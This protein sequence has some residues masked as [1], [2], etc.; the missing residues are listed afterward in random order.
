MFNLRLDNPT[1]L[2]QTIAVLNDFI[3]EATFSFQKDGIKLVAM[4]PA[5]I[6]MVSLDLLPSAFSEYN[7]E[8]AKELTLNLNYLQQALNR[9]RSNDAIT[10]AP[11]K[12][13]LKVTILGKS[14]KRFFIP[15]L[16]KEGKERA[17]PDLSFKAKIELDTNEFK[18]Y[19]DD[20]SVVGDAMTFEA[21]ED[22]INLSAGEIGSQ[23]QIEVKKDSAAIVNF[24]V[25]EKVRS[26]FSIEY[27]KKIANSAKLA[28]SVVM[29]LSNDYPIKLDF[30][31]LNKLKIEFILAP[32]IEN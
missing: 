12:N 16:E 25:K 1:L 9:A 30:K 13:R 23:V 8:K 19:I 28:E 7:V 5:N 11:E 31:S 22:K 10:I 15:L 18:D 4:D 26:I 6:C 17:A 21:A 27:L 29:N 3:T 20:A 14:T 32:R 2:K 24:E